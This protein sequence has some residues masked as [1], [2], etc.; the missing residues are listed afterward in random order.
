MDRTDVF[1]MQTWNLPVYLYTEGPVFYVGTRERLQAELYVEDKNGDNCPAKS[2]GSIF[3]NTLISLTWDH[4]G[5]WYQYC[6][7]HVL[8]TQYLSTSHST[9]PP[10]LE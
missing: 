5:I 6:T 10:Y 9:F 7:H 3:L 4:T 2:Q 8:P 1:N